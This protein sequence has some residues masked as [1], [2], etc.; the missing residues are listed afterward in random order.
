MQSKK[1][2]KYPDQL[3]ML[4][5]IQLSKINSMEKAQIILNMSMKKSLLRVSLS[6]AL[7]ILIICININKGIKNLINNGY[8]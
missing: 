4:K 8:K 3:K 6:K 1:T 2:G 5:N 7:T